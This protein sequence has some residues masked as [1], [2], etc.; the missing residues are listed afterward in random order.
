MDKIG[1]EKWSQKQTETHLLL[2]ASI[3][4]EPGNG[5]N[6]SPLISEEVRDHPQ[7]ARSNNEAIGSKIGLQV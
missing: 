2:D 1:H 5:V 7:K 3:G 6:V 4:S